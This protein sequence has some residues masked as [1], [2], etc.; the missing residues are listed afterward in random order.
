MVCRLFGIT[1]DC[2]ESVHFYIIMDSD[3]TNLA[4]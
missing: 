1:Q 4:W 3:N 2:G